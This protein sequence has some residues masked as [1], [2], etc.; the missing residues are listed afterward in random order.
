MESFSIILLI[1]RFKIHLIVIGVIVC[2]AGGIG[3][4]TI[5]RVTGGGDDGGEGEDRRPNFQRNH[6]SIGYAAVEQQQLAV[7]QNVYVHVENA[8][9]VVVNHHLFD[10]AVG[11]FAQL[12]EDIVRKRPFQR[13]AVLLDDNETSLGQPDDDGQET[14]TVFLFQYQIEGLPLRLRGKVGDLQFYFF[15]SRFRFRAQRY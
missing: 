12:D 14:V 3:N 9:L 13:N 2:G 8:V 15:H 11:L 10:D 4:A 1:N 5:F 6:H 7:P